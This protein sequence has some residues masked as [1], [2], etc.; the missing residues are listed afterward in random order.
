[1]QQGNHDELLHRE[2]HGLVRHLQHRPGQVG[3]GGSRRQ[4]AD[5]EGGGTKHEP[6]RP[7]GP[8]QKVNPEVDQSQQKERTVVKVGS[9]K[10]EFSFIHSLFI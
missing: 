1:M 7:L 3:A 8:H 6:P 10:Y 4:E 2:L 5:Q 9:G